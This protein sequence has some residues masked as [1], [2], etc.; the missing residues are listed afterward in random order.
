MNF[1]KSKLKTTLDF[2][3]TTLFEDI[4][5]FQNLRPRYLCFLEVNEK[6]EFPCFANVQN[7]P[8][9]FDYVDHD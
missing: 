9:P 5:E 3:L 7:K 4:C 1:L 2:T 6:E 8:N